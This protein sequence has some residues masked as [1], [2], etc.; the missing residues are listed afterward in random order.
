VNAV[1]TL[2][3][4]VRTENDSDAMPFPSLIQ[5]NCETFLYCPQCSLSCASPNSWGSI[6]FVTILLLLL[7]LVDVPKTHVTAV[8]IV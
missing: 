3:T 2:A 6:S 5:W 8:I 4:L 7:L 1:G